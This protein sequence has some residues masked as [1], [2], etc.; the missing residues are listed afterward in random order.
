MI[1]SNIGSTPDFSAIYTSN[2]GMH[3]AT[4]QVSLKEDHKIGSYEYMARVRKR[5]RAARCPR[6]PPTSSRAVW[7][8]RCSAWA[9]RRPST[10]RSP[11]PTCS[12]ATA[13][14]TQL[15]RQIR[16]IHGVGDIYHPA[17]SRLSGAAARYRPHARRGTGPHAKGSGRQ[18]H[19]R[20]HL[21][22]HDRPQF[23]DRSQD[24]QRLHADGA[25]SRSADP[26]LRRSARHSHP[27]RG[28]ARFHAPRRGL[29]HPAHQIAHRSGPLPAAPRDR[30]LRAAARRRPGPD[31]Q[32]RSTDSPRTPRS[33][34]ASPSRCAAWCKACGRASSSFGI[35]LTL[36]VVLLYLILVAQ[37]RSFLDPLLILTAVPPGLTGA[38]LILYLTGTSMNV[39]SLMGLMIL[40]G[41]TVSDS[42]LIVE[43]TRHLREDGMTVR[44]AVVT[45]ARV[46]LAPRA[47]D[48]A[49]HH[50]RPAADGAEAWRRQRSRTRRWPAPCW[51][52]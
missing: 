13:T 44:Q 18:H 12:R 37:F 27:R 23:L 26:E 34:R 33:R 41:M 50:H 40:I 7:W 48:V 51:A 4:V 21:E 17:G 22:R 24:R 39:M 15:A 35:G 19:H 25:V 2:S 8:M 9:C 10:C 5:D 29:Q 46:R 43:F 1:V 6:S 11:A 3:T 14:A 32:R 28:I 38:L 45:A 52:A 36:S 47:D 42:I 16:K 20:S 49:R 30:R 31:R